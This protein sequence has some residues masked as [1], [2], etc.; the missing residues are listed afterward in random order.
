MIQKLD[1]KRTHQL[2][3]L[4]DG[5]RAVGA[6]TIAKY[7]PSSP[8]LM[9]WAYKCGQRGENFNDVRDKAA[10]IGTCGHFLIECFLNGDTADLSD[11]STEVIE[12]AEQAFA[13]FQKWWIEGGF[14]SLK[15]E[16]QLVSETHRYGGTL[17]NICLDRDSR[18]CLL[19]FKVTTGIYV[20]HL[21]QLSGYEELHNENFDE[22][23][24]RR[25]IVRI[26][27]E[28]KKPQVKWLDKPD[29]YFQVFL[30]RLEL[31]N[32]ERGLSV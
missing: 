32:L 25:A 20:E 17:D 5:T 18:L 16:V 22:K 11:F 26:P 10:N 29:P 13:N 12:T 6:S 21:Y 23:I 3:H 9:G 14:T 19:D 24:T 27:K 7:G 1:R 30:K 8:A 2:Y 28:E 4:A 31:Y 15:S